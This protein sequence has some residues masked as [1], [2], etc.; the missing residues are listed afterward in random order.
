MPAM[1]RLHREF[2]GKGLVILAVNFR[3]TEEESRPFMN[4]LGLTF[5]V[6]LDKDGKV[7]EEYGT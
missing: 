2:K 6:L 1:E 3:E 7:S 5:T 4:E